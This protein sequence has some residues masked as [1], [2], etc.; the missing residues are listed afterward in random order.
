MARRQREGGSLTSCKARAVAPVFL[1][2]GGREPEAVRA[3]HAG[4]V[5]AAAGGAI[6][7]VVV[8][9]GEDTDPDR[10]SAALALAGAREVREFVVSSARPP[11]RPDLAGATGVFVAGGW[12][13]GH[14]DVLVGA[15]TDW[16]ERGPPHAGYSAGAG[17]AG[18][19]PDPRRRGPR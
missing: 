12:T 11:S 3:S 7:V 5:C 10:W 8:D 19:P 15:G 18:P 16:L 9:E 17:P 6:A 4:F 1:I 13:P 2:G 14:H